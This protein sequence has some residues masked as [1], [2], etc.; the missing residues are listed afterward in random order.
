VPRVLTA[1]WVDA[2]GPARA[3]FV[4]LARAR[5]DILRASGC[6]YWVFENHARPGTFLEFLEA[7]DAES[8]RAARS[9]VGA[10]GDAPILSEVRLD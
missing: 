7:S 4:A 6:N 1:E 5:R 10:S 8:L 9:A 2:A 3:A